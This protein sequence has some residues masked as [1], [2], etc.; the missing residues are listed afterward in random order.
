MSGGAV[1][2]LRRSGSGVCVRCCF[3]FPLVVARETWRLPAAGAAFA[4]VKDEARRFVLARQW[5]A[6]LGLP[7][8]DPSAT[9]T[10]TEMPPTPEQ[11]WLTDEAGRRCTSEPRFVA[12]HTR[13]G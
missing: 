4:D 10:F 6:A 1:R 12:L 9:A 8:H 5:R 13:E 11:T 2:P 3:F 7:R